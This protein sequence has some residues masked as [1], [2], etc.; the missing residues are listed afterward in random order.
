MTLFPYTTLF[1]SL[2][3]VEFFGLG[4]R[5]SLCIWMAWKPLFGWHGSL[6]LGGVEAFG[7]SGMG[8]FIW[9]GMKA[10]GLDGMVAFDLGWHESLWFGL[11]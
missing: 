3:G 2:G 9:V 10:F 11:A 6:Y 8:A 4:W 1:R 5:G 7:L